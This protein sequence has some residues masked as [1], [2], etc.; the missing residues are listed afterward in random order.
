MSVVGGCIVHCIKQRHRNI[1]IVAAYRVEYHP[2]QVFEM[3]KGQI[4]CPAPS[5]GKQM[6]DSIV[7]KQVADA[8]FGA[9]R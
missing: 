2:L 4:W 7:G 3:I 8:V 5:V 1:G 6:A 9:F